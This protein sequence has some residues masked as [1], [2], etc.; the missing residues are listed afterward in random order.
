MKTGSGSH[1]VHKAVNKLISVL[2]IFIV[3]FELL[4]KGSA[5]ML[6]HTCEFCDDQHRKAVFSLRA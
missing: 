3:S 1:T 4:G 5:N 6:L 2:S